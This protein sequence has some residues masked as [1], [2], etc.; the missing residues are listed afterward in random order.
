[1]GLFRRSVMF[2]LGIGCGIYAEQNYNMPNVK[3]L[4]ET[5]VFLT[6]YLAETYRKPKK[7]DE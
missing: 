6:R 5:Y 1:M 7:D 4:V 3:K 2:M